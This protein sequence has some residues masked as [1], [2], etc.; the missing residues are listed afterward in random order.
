M[1]TLILSDIHGN[2]PALRAVLES[3]ADA[4]RILCLGDLVNYGPQSA[5]C[6]AWAKRHLPSEWVIQ[7]N[8]D[9]ALALGTVPRCAP[10]NRRWAE[11]MQTATSALLTPELKRFLGELEP[12][13]QFHFGEAILVACHSHT[14]TEID[15]SLDAHFGEQDPEWPWES[16]IILCDH[17]DKLFV[18]VGHPD[19]VSYTHLTLPTIYSV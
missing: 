3:E 9:R 11:A 12:L 17:P 1:K 5:E 18:L 4:E 15:Q 14:A 19:A 13:R 8:H 10:V 6:V 16:D 2:W 7:G